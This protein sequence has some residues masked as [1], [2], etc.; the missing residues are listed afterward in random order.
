MTAPNTCTDAAPTWIYE[1]DQTPIVSVKDFLK[2]SIDPLKGLV[3]LKGMSGGPNISAEYSLTITGYLPSGESKSFAFIIAINPCTPI[4]P[5]LLG[6]TYY[7]NFPMGSY[8]A[9][10]F[11]FEAICLTP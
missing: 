6:Q 8:D 5:T 9:P 1:I 11:T 3:W 2:V 10:A 7:N 4:I